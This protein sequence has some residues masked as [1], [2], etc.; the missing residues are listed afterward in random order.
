MPSTEITDA[1]K[2]PIPDLFSWRHNMTKLAIVASGLILTLF[3]GVLSAKPA[4]ECEPRKLELEPVLGQEMTETI[5][6]TATRDLGLTHPWVSSE[7]Q[8]YIT[9]IEPNGPT[10]AM[11]GDSIT[12]EINFLIPEDDPHASLDFTF[13]VRE[14]LPGKKGRT[15]SGPVPIT[16]DLIPDWGRVEFG[17]LEFWLPPELLQGATPGENQVTVGGTDPWGVYADFEIE[18][19]PYP[20]SSREEALRAISVSRYDYIDSDQMFADG[21]LLVRADTMTGAHR[22]FLNSDRTLFLEVT[23]H[24]TTMESADFARIIDS[25]SFH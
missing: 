15:H 3:S 22:L 23:A 18:A 13:H 2:Q 20:D 14:Y 16:I 4:M 24:I 7:G 10:E 21:S 9:H 25:L 5:T 6:C 19:N 12:Y 17:D 8:P 1:A 11:K